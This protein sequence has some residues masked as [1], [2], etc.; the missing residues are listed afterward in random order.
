MRVLLSTRGSRG[1]VEPMAALAVRL[2]DLG[3]EALVCAPPDDEF[4]AVLARAG[5]P[6]V[7]VGRSQRSLLEGAGSGDM[8]QRVAE[9]VATTYEA[10]VAAAEGCD[11][12][13]ATGMFPAV[14]GARAAAEKLGLRYVYTCFQPTMLPSPHHP[15]FEYPGRPHPAG[16][17]DNRVLWDLDAENMNALFGG[18]VNEH[19]R[20]V[21]LAP[22]GNLRDHLFTERP[23]LATDPTL[24]PWVLPADLDV[25]QTGAW[26]LPDERPLPADLEA[27]LD[28]GAPPV[29]VGFGSMPV[30][31]DI[32][33]T[34]V[35][36]VRAQRHRV[37]LARGWAGLTQVDDGDDCFVVGEV[38]QQALFRRV[39]AVVHHGGA[40]TMTAA[41]TA[42]APQVV[43]PQ[44]VDQPYYARRVADLEIG[45][46]HDGPAPTVDS[47]AAALGSALEAD[48]RER[49][50][51]VA[52]EIRSDGAV[53]AAKALLA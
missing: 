37:L 13:V 48:V 4:A 6:F 33:K 32:A 44:M 45:V 36:A 9:M 1:D 15:P 52:R 3:A 21:G 28:A 38:N 11:V 5:V 53:V 26:V 35:E 7:P 17:E 31:K 39:A 22:V 43:V 27:F 41:A 25:V 23:W 42:G 12:V 20:S 47:L 8:A 40:G 49:A 51:A 50:A 10:V 19:R 29:Y 34:A 30:A 18:P 14:A 2:R 16:V 24:S 46:A